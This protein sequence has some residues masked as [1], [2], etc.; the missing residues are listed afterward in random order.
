MRDTKK[1]KYVYCRSVRSDKWRQNKN[2][3]TCMR[4]IIL[5]TTENKKR[6][7]KEEKKL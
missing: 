3:A 7:K 2:D 1:Q 5:T 6:K 4:Y